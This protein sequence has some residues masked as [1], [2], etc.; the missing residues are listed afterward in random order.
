MACTWRVPQGSRDNRKVVRLNP[1]EPTVA[2]RF[3]HCTSE[4]LQLP[5]QFSPVLYSLS[6]WSLHSCSPC[7]TRLTRFEFIVSKLFTSSECIVGNLTYFIK[8]KRKKRGGR[9]RG[10]PFGQ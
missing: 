1:G 8:K 2:S 10:I 3:D 7:F 9:R 4:I 6:R 5:P